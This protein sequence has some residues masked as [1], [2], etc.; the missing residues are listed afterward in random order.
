MGYRS[1]TIDV[2]YRLRQLV[3]VTTAIP[4]SHQQKSTGKGFGGQRDMAH[5]VTSRLLSVVTCIVYVT[6]RRHLPQ[7]T[8]KLPGSQMPV[9]LGYI[10]AAKS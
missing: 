2:A 1:M 7:L 6:E 3:E 8:L 9:V 10:T 5:S 4:L